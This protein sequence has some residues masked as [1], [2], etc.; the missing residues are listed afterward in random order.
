[1]DTSFDYN[2]KFDYVRVYQKRGGKF[3]TS[4]TGNGD[5][6]DF[7]IP[8]T[9][10]PEQG[11]I[12][13]VTVGDSDRDADGPAEFF[14]LNGRKIKSAAAMPAGIYIERRGTSAKKIIVK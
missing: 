12:E 8:A 4:I 2:T 11:A 13:Q 6:P 1:A 10:N 9:G 5:D 14:D 3:T 7:Y